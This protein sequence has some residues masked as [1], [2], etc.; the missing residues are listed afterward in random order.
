MVLCY[1]S[2]MR[3][4]L[5][6]RSYGGP[7]YYD[8]VLDILVSAGLAQ[9]LPASRLRQYINRIRPLPIGSDTAI[10]CF[11][12]IMRNRGTVYYMPLSQSVGS[13]AV[14]KVSTECLFNTELLRC[15]S[16]VFCPWPSKVTMMG[17]VVL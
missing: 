10:L 4:P 17:K 11:I 9:A 16:S 2:V 6:D 7:Q 1:H 12:F 5:R 15:S 3:S 14:I 13:V 8:T